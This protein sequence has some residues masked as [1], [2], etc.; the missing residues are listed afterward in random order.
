V[1]ILKH[2]LSI[3]S[4]RVARSIASARDSGAQ[5]DAKA[6]TGPACPTC[7]GVQ[8]PAHANG[9]QSRASSLLEAAVNVIAGFGLALLGQGIILPVFGV[10]LSMA[11]HSGVAGFFTALSLVRS[12]LLRRLFDH[13]DHLRREEERARQERLRQAFSRGRP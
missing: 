13:I 4:R 2:V 9:R 5:S 6:C 10:H 11:A 7:S 3:T 8:S 12:Y 1:T